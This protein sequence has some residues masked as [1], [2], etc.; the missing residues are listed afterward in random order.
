MAAGSSRRAPR[1]PVRSVRLLL[2]ALMVLWAMRPPRRAALM[3]AVSRLSLTLCAPPR[4]LLLWLACGMGRLPLMSAG[5]WLLPW[6]AVDPHERV[7]GCS[8]VELEPDSMSLDSEIAID[9]SQP[10]LLNLQSVYRMVKE[11]R[12]FTCA[13]R[14]P[15]PLGASNTRPCQASRK[16]TTSMSPSST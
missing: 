11:P 15:C 10:A 7:V 13:R 5:E 3:G 14:V 2:S 6:L 1:G 16:P 12:Y 8:F 4:G 9:V